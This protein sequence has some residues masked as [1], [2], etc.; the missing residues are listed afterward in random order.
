MKK[1]LIAALMIIG[2]TVSVFALDQRSMDPNELSLKAGPTEPGEQLS[3]VWLEAFIYPKTIK[4]N[5]TVSM[6]VKLPNAVREVTAAFDFLKQPIPLAS[7]NNKD[8]TAVTQLPDNIK[9]GIHV[10]RYQIV[11]DKG[12]IQRTLD[13]FVSSAS[14]EAAA[15]NTKQDLSSLPLTVV[16]SS[17]AYVDGVSRVLNAGQKIVG[18]AKVPWYKVVLEDG[19]EGWLPAS[20]VNDPAQELC[21]RGYQAY[22]AGN[23]SQA[24][25]FYQQSVAAEPTLVKGHLWLAKSY[26]KTQEM[27]NAY[28]SAM[29]AMR[30]DDRDM[31]CK[32]FA[33]SLASVIY[34][35]AHEKFSQARFNEAIEGF[36]KVLALKPTSY[37]TWIELGQSYDQ[38]GFAQEARWAWREALKLNPQ[39]RQVYALLK[40]NNNADVFTNRPMDRQEKVVVAS[41]PVTDIPSGLADDSLSIVKYEKTKKGTKIESAIR[42]VL[43]LTKSLGTPVVEKGWRV[44]KDGKNYVVSYLVEQGSGALEA[45]EWQVDV[46][47]KHVVA[48]NENAKVLMTRW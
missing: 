16:A 27:D 36:Q 45:F 18:I 26:A 1:T 23:F 31:S 25:K 33:Q 22:Q 21:Q 12:S 41:K 20:M 15:E 42:S 5:K 9:V 2:L 7:N 17:M 8:W 28:R 39:D 32:L 29:E 24:V 46:D 3:F 40:I 44:K 35:D 37:A 13:F 6:G 10:V 11:S 19:K 30:L 34:D 43:T 48:C 47:T 14:N 38:L 4:E